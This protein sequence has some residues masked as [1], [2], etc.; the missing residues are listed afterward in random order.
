[1]QITQVNIKSYPN[2]NHITCES[3]FELSYRKSEK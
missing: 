2:L 3:E 1:M